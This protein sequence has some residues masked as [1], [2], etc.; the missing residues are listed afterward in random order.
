MFTKNAR[1]AGIDPLFGEILGELLISNAL[2]VQRTESPS[3]L[4]GMTALVVGGA[5]R[6]G[7]WCCRRLANRGADVKVWDRRGRLEGYENLDSLD[8]HASTAD[9]VVVASPL[10][11]CPDDLREVFGR[12]PK[13]LVFD[14][15]S[16]KAH[17]S[18]ILQKA[19]AAGV[20][21]ASAHPMFGPN[22]PSPKGQIVIVCDCGS[23]EGLAQAK[24]L[25]LGGGAKVVEVDIGKHDE[26]MA[27]VLGL[28]HLTS[29]LFAGSLAKSG[30]DLDEL[31][32]VQGPS[33]GRMLRLSNDI[34]QESIR[35][36]H[37]IQSLNPK[38]R[39]MFGAV[40]K[41]LQELEAASLEKDHSRFKKI[42][43]ANRKYLEV[44]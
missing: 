31:I 1:M 35:I 7:S 37:D 4:E 3:D 30:K 13:G 9:I 23:A 42:M 15:C 32:A 26:L 33:F 36:Y 18:K 14:I 40:N 5:G 8:R 20:K 2:K 12:S 25:F 11:A 24:R 22:V 41:A 16:V 44:R 19:A 21:V 17:L 28:P 10:G 6:M 34:A 38:T 43:E 39:R 29:L 27:Y